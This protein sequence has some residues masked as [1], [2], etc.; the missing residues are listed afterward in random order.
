M[1]EDIRLLLLTGMPVFP[2]IRDF[3]GRE[4]E[5]SRDLADIWQRFLLPLG[6]GLG[7]DALLW[8]REVVG[9][10]KDG[11]GREA[12]QHCG[13]RFLSTVWGFNKDLGVRCCASI[14][15]E[16]TEEGFEFFEFS[17][18]VAMEGKAKS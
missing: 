6:N 2:L 15:F 7:N 9:K 16:L 8:K 17:R 5:N 18:K 1:V 13:E 3:R 4:E 14:G 12:S 10:G 11:I